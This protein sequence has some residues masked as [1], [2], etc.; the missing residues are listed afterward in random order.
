MAR[1]IKKP[2]RRL[3]RSLEN[4]RYGLGFAKDYA[5]KSKDELLAAV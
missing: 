4:G 2:S 5:E 3:I 1:P